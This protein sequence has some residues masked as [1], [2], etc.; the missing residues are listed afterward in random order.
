MRFPASSLNSALIQLIGLS[1]FVMGARGNYTA[2]EERFE[3]IV[4]N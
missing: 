1:P 3:R 2:W 4:N